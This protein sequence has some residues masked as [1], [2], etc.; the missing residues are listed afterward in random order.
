M[1]KA[2]SNSNQLHN[3]Y[4]SFVPELKQSRYESRVFAHQY[5]TMSPEVGDFDE[6]ARRRYDILKKWLGSVGEG[7]FIEPPFIPDYGVNMIIGKG[8]YMNFGCVKKS[9]PWCSWQ[10]LTCRQVHRP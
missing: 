6:A 5:N 8:S 1:V 10:T 7:V 3:R 4:D 9:M 2:G